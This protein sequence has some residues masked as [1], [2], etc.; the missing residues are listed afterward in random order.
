MT[1]S[2]AADEHKPLLSSTADDK[3]SLAENAELERRIRDNLAK[4]LASSTDYT[5]N[6]IADLE[7]V[8][9]TLFPP[10]FCLEKETGGIIRHLAIHSQ[11]RLKPSARITSHRRFIGP[12]IVKFKRLFWPLLNLHL[13]DQFVAME[14]F[15]CGAVA[16][17]AWQAA[18]IQELR[19]KL[20]EL[21]LR[22]KHH[23]SGVNGQ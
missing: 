10:D 14:E 20:A 23:S 9:P 18:E 17:I 19:K 3:D 8:A 12:L 5:A 7:Q 16:A 21:E 6:E 4:R 15:S 2:F 11:Q 22:V 13:R 1:N